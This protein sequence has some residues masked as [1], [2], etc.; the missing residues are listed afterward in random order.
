MKKETGA[1]GSK[2]VAAQVL[3]MR[4][5]AAEGET[6]GSLAR[7]FRVSVGQVGRILRFEAWQELAPPPPSDD[8]LT[9]LLA[10]QAAV[11][12]SASRSDAE[13]RARALLKGLN[14]GTNPPK[15]NV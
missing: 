11:A 7:A 10:T 6:Q 14:E 9:R 8:A 4:R 2:L 5:R 15:E 12:A 13:A 3:E 1:Q